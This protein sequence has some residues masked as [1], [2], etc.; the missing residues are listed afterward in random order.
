MPLKVLSTEVLTEQKADAWIR[1]ARYER[2]N[3]RD[4]FARMTAVDAVRRD[5]SVMLSGVRGNDPT[6]EPMLPPALS[7]QISKFDDPRIA[8][9][10]Y[11]RD[12]GSPVLVEFSSRPSQKFEG[13]LRS[14]AKRRGLLLHFYRLIGTLVVVKVDQRPPEKVQVESLSCDGCRRPPTLAVE[15]VTQRA[16]L[17]SLRLAL[18]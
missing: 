12:T 13:D 11:A 10:W 14:S 7:E 16:T 17:K 9:L 6:P 4:R 15:T 18:T 2:R 3:E 8:L 1:G 5:I